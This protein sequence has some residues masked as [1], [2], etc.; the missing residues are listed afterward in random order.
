MYVK[1]PCQPLWN[2]LME[3]LDFKR[4][5]I[6]DLARVSTGRHWGKYTWAEETPEKI[7]VARASRC[8]S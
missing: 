2:E 6:A 3:K 5:Q 8:C 1:S 4:P 7:V